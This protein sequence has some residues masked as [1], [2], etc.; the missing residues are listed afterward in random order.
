MP[1]GVITSHTMKRS[2]S[3]AAGVPKLWTWREQFPAPRSSTGVSAA[4]IRRVG[5]WTLAGAVATATR[6]PS[7]ELTVTAFSVPEYSTSVGPLKT[8]AR[9]ASWYFSPPTLTVK[10][11]LSGITIR[12]SPAAGSSTAAPGGQR[13]H[14]QSRVCPTVHAEGGVGCAQRNVPAAFGCAAQRIYPVGHECVLFRIV[15]GPGPVL[16]RLRGGARG[17]GDGYLCTRVISKL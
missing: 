17:T 9:P 4:V 6:P 5:Y 13:C 16:K 11:P 3:S 15:S 8:L 7:D 10:A 2:A 1:A 12:S 14:L